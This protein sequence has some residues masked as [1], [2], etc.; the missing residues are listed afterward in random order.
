MKFP[1]IGSILAFAVIVDINWFT[2]MVAEDDLGMSA[3]FARDIL[4]GP[5]DA[6]ERNG[7]EVVGYMG[8][9]ILGIL[10]DGQTTVNACFNIAKD[11]DRLCE[12]I[13]TNR[14]GGLEDWGFA[15]TQDPSIKIAVE[16]SSVSISTISSRFLGNRQLFVGDAINYASRILAAGIGNRCHVGSVAAAAIE[17]FAESRLHGPLSVRGKRG[18][19]SYSYYKFDLGDYWIERP[20]KKG[21]DTYWG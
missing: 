21:K 16:S 14:T 19:G 18:E 6:I 11:L 1:E 4:A 3:Q 9:A 20:R 5:I 17:P 8:D 12:W 13:S 7:G 10:P 2:K 15:P